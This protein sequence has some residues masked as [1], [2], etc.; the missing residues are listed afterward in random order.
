M[1]KGSQSKTSS[2][3]PQI[4]TLIIIGEGEKG[5]LMLILMFP[6]W[7]NSSCQMFQGILASIIGDIATYGS[8]KMATKAASLSYQESPFWDQF[9]EMT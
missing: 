3:P 1:N 6:P 4:A 2:I 5:I 8:G 7:I 9:I